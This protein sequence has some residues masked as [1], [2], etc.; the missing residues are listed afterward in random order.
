[1]SDE[2]AIPNVDRGSFAAI[3]VVWI[4]AAFWNGILMTIVFAVRKDAG[5]TPAVLYAVCAPFVVAGIYL[6]RLAASATLR[7]VHY[8]SLVL[9]LDAPGVVGGRMTELFA[10]RKECCATA[11]RSA[12]G[13]GA[14]RS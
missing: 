14:R 12:C 11:C 6:I 4:F 7:T 5:T 2:L 8:S 9:R 3:A 10:V 13:A 1:V